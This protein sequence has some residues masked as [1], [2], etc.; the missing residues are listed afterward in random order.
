LPEN[1][2]YRQASGRYRDPQ[3]GVGCIFPAGY[4][5][6]CQLIDYDYLEHIYQEQV[7]AK[8]RACL[9][10]LVLAIGL[11]GCVTIGQ[12]DYPVYPGF[13]KAPAGLLPIR[14]SIAIS[15]WPRR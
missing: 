10:S 7:M 5:P 2:V 11:C 9:L 8:V 3:E 6:D 4:L 1:T 15:L 13:K 14:L 12:S